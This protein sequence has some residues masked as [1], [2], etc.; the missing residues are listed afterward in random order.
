MVAYHVLVVCVLCV[1]CVVC[2]V[3]CCVLWSV[4]RNVVCG[5]YD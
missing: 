3:M 5:V 2:G 4:L 1:S